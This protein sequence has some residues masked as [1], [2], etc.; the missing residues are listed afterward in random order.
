MS[1]LG[2]VLEAGLEDSDTG[3]DAQ[4]LLELEEMELCRDPQ[5]D[6]RGVLGDGVAFISASRPSRASARV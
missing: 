6:D 4:L 1:G 5:R 2:H 3:D